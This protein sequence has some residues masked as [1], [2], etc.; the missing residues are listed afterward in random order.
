MPTTTR[1]T[2]STSFYSLYF[3]RPCETTLRT[4]WI[5]HSIRFYVNR[6]YALCPKYFRI[7]RFP[8]CIPGRLCASPCGLY[9]MYK[10]Q[11]VG[12]EKA[13]QIHV[14][15]AYSLSATSRKSLG[16]GVSAGYTMVSTGRLAKMYLLRTPVVMLLQICPI[17]IS[18][19][20]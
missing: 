9:S 17:G 8:Q 5:T 11:L 10:V 16:S 4:V 13:V 19:K 6:T 20:L 18:L 12:C 7:F 2:V 14:I 1:G 15:R 3:L